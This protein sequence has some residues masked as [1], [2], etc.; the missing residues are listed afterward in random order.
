MSENQF[1]TYLDQ[2]NVLSP[3]HS[4]IYDEY[5]LNSSRE[6]YSFTISTKVEEHLKSIFN[7]KPQSVIL[8]GNAGDGKTRICRLIYDEYSK[9]KLI[10]WPVEGIVEVTYKD[11]VLVI[12]K[13]LSE[14]KEDVIVKIL[15]DLQECV[16]TQH[17]QKKYYLIA[18]N[19]GKLTKTLSKYDHLSFIREEILKRFSSYK[20]NNSDFSI[21]NLLDVT[22]SVYVEK[23]LEEWNKE[24]NWQTC[25]SCLKN[26]SCIIYLNHQRTAKQNIQQKIVE[27]Y[28]LLDYLDTHITMREMLIHISYILT[29]GYTCKDIQNADYEKLEEQAKR[30]YYQNFY[31]H[32]TGKEAFTE[33]KALRVFRTLDP[34]GYSHTLIDDFIINGDINGVSILED[35]HKEIFNNDLDLQQGYFNKKLRLYREHSSLQDN[36]FI[37]EWIPRLR[38]KLFF[39]LATNE[40]INTLHLLP[41]EYLEEYISLFGDKAKQSKIRRDLVNGLNRAFSNRL[42]KNEKTLS[43]KATNENLMIYG[44]FNNRQIEL[45][46]ESDR[47]DLDHRSSV[48]DLVV[49]S[50]VELP[51]NLAVFEYLMRLSG[52]GTH[53]ILRQ[54]VEILINTFKNELIKA[55]ELDEYNLEIYR[56]DRES[57][58]YIEDEITL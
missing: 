5:T 15:K 54:D 14:L 31:G 17:Q 50:E 46:E 27:Q 34:G 9:D 37:E 51:V 12:V 23:V 29:G 44:N 55:S 8:T 52:G 13:D 32:E 53:N 33:M 43:L 25:Q 38:R 41:F 36:A 56:L 47:A 24:D 40:F 11:Q 30:I 58:L 49:N 42:V 22:S 1:V 57:G 2:F 16:Q 45:V 6:N 18:A 19:E 28:R 20:E 3:N 48:F 7:E 35:F 10:E 21:I 26:K 39:E 4:K